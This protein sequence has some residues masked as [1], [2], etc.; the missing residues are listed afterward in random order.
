MCLLTC[1]QWMLKDTIGLEFATNLAQSW[2]D[3]QTKILKLFCPN[4][5]QQKRLKQ[6]P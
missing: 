6:V 1:E 5:E 2:V 4:T 3:D